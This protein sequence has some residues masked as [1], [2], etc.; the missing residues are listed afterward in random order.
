MKLQV[1]VTETQEI[2]VLWLSVN[3]SFRR[4]EQRL[5]VYLS[6]DRGVARWGYEQI[7]DEPS[8]LDI[9]LTLL[10]DCV[11]CCD[12]PLHLI[13]HSTGGLVGLLYARQYP[14]RVK[15]LTLLGVGVNPAIDWKAHYYAQL[16]L[17]PC[18]RTRILTQMAVS[19]FGQQCPHYLISLIETLESDLMTSLSLHSLL[20]QASLLPGGV[21]VPLMVAGGQAD[22]VVDPMQLQGW[23]SW[24][25]PGDRIW[26]CPN[27]R[28][29]FHATHAQT[30]AQAILNFW[31]VVD[32]LDK[33]PSYIPSA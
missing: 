16:K 21:P 5:L 27:G 24:M 15:S 2:D 13:G 3:P 19:L 20:R 18:S 25:K 32:P 9:A 33:M 12:R 4:L 30:T 10:H 22:I 11:K 23:Q 26:L 31:H 6:N 14:K 28:Q 29:F 7:P 1:S 17:L 8:S